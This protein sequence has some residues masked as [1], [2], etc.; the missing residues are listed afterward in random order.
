MT[1]K[2]RKQWADQ[3]NLRPFRIAGGEIF[4]RL[5]GVRQFPTQNSLVTHGFHNS[6]AW[7]SCQYC[8]ASRM[9]HSCVRM[10]PPQSN[11]TQIRPICPNKPGSPAHNPRATPTS[12]R[13]PV[14]NHPDSPAVRAPNAPAAGPPPACSPK[15]SSQTSN[16]TPPSLARN[17]TISLGVAS[18][19]TL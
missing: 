15:F 2:A 14:C 11:P 7:Y 4:R 6:L 16:G 19:G 3:K 13:P 5:F 17:T 1:R 18:T 8:F 9:S 10:S 12:P